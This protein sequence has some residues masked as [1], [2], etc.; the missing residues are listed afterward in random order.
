M[1]QLA[2]ARPSLLRR[3]LKPLITAQVSVAASMLIGDTACQYIARNEAHASPP[4]SLSYDSPLPSVS[5]IQPYIPTWLDPQRSLVMLFTGLFISGPW[6]AVTLSTSEYLFPGRAMKSVLCKVLMNGLISP[7]G[8]SLSFTSIT[9][10]EG[11]SVQQA[12]EKVTNDLTST[13]L[14][15]A[16]YWPIVSGL[17]F[18]FVPFD[19][20]PLFGGLAGAAWG[21]YMSKQAHKP[22][23]KESTDLNVIPLTEINKPWTTSRLTYV[24]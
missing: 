8:I 11:R 13:W 1:A 4:H 3:A 15:G 10:L 14:T 17:N 9:L 2:I 21:T 16:L 20:R 23:P 19:Y 6:S 5:F 7:I 18:R 22:T 12:K 24:I